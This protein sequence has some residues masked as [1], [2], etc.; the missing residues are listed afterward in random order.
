MKKLSIIFSL[1]IAGISCFAWL[2]G[3]E[4]IIG[5]DI[6]YERYLGIASACNSKESVNV[7]VII[8]DYERASLDKQ[9]FYRDGILSKK[10]LKTMFKYYKEDYDNKHLKDDGYDYWVDLYVV[11]NKGVVRVWYILPRNPVYEE[12]YSGVFNK[13]FF[14]KGRYFMELFDETGNSVETT[15]I[16]YDGEQVFYWMSL[17]QVDFDVIKL[18]NDV[19]RQH[20]K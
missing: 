8:T 6:L 3:D 16:T 14:D 19:K 15:E 20:K 2:S 1:L 13:W 10:E 17:K 5:P 7:R 18:Y 9:K 4:E 11:N 12:K